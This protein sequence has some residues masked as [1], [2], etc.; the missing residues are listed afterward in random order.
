MKKY[1][2][3]NKNVYIGLDVHKKKYALTARCEGIVVKKDVIAACAEQLIQYVHNQFPGAKLYTAY[4]AGFCG[5][6]LHRYLREQGINNIV[7]HPSSIEVAVRDRVKTDKRDSMK[8]ATQLE[9]GRLRGIHI[10]A[11]E[12][13]QYREVS[14]L[15]EE[16][17]RKRKQLSCQIKSLLARHGLS[18]SIDNK[19]SKRWIYQFEKGELP[20]GVRFAFEQYSLAWLQLNEQI[21]RIDIE[22]RKQGI[23]DSKIQKIIESVPGIGLIV[24]RTIANELGDMSQFSNV[25][26]LYSFTGLTPQE[27]SSGEHRR[28]G[29]ITRQGRALLRKTLVQ[30]AWVAIRYDTELASIFHR[31]AKKAGAKKAI[32][33]VARKLIGRVRACL[34]RGEEYTI[35]ERASL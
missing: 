18:D 10:P 1:N 4:E 29:H 22:L 12:R 27:Y 35:L 26:K 11:T 25:R 24:G 33:A 23:E 6:R 7:V 14:R 13:E 32:V 34:K 28:L 21:K 20:L 30:A 16:L 3:D 5:F 31:I 17:L 19:I 15:R 9:A 8:I 2:Y